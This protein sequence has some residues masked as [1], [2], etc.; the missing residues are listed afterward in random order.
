M[1]EVV[2]N[3]MGWIRSNANL[4]GCSLSLILI[5][6]PIAAIAQPNPFVQ[7]SILQLGTRGQEVT[8]LQAVLK[9]LG[10]YTGPVDGIYN[11]G[12]VRGVSAF[13]QAA[14]LTPD[15]IVGEGTWNRL[16]PPSPGAIASGFGNPGSV[17]FIQ[18]SRPILRQ[19]ME[20]DLVAQLQQRLNQLGFFEGSPTGVFGPRTDASVRALQRRYNL[21]P[22]GIV[23]PSTWAILFP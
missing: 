22:D 3:P 8:E 19:G 12:T 13:Q 15:G 4:I 14:G 23:G 21:E 17:P 18:S 9:L 7:R 16:F 6:I 1:T 20:S 11:E 2:F 5:A 10:Y